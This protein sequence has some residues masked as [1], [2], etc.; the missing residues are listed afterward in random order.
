MEC[1]RRGPPLRTSSILVL[2]LDGF[3]G[4]MDLLLDLAK[5]QRIDLGRMSALALAEQFVAAMAKL[6]DRLPLEQRV[7]WLV[8]ATRLVH[9]H[10]TAEFLPILC[11]EAPYRVLKARAAVASTFLTGLELAREGG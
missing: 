4:P 2:H 3:D 6:A 11:L 1:Q 9:L 8:M 5:R 10:A 7:D